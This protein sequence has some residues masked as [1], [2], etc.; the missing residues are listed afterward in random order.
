[1]PC[2]NCGSVNTKKYGKVRGKQRYYC[3]DCNTTFGHTTGTV[4]INS[5]VN[6]SKWKIMLRGF[7]ENQ[8]M[9]KIAKEAGLSPS[10]VWINKI[11]LCTAIM[12]LY[13]E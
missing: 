6:E 1:M 12:S 2:S 5:K 11:K 7:I 8:S 3:K 10:S 4:L 9:S 13:G